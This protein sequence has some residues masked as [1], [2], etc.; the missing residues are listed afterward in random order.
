[1]AAL[2]VPGS[3]INVVILAT[4]L[5]QMRMIANELADHARFAQRI[6]DRVLPQFDRAPGPPQ[7]VPRAAQDVVPR[8]HTGE[9]CSVVV[10]ETHS[11]LR[12]PVYI[13]RGEFGA[14]IGADHVAIEAIE[15]KDDR[16]FRDH[17]A[18]LRSE[19]ASVRQPN[20]V[21]G[22]VSPIMRAVRSATTRPPMVSE[23]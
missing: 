22:T 21:S 8:R 13:R 7:E 19:S 17:L 3:E 11:A 9:R 6:G 18:W 14:A 12:Q 2:I 10:G 15:K 5:E 16:V 23:K 1:M 4:G 20:A